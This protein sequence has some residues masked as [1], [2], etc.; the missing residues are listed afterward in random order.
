MEEQ[1][2]LKPP[3]TRPPHL[4]CGSK[5]WTGVALVSCAYFAWKAYGRVETGGVAWSHDM[6]AI[7]THLVWIVFMVGLLTETRCWK[8]RAFFVL[9]LINFALGFTMG[10]WHSATGEAVHTTRLISAAAWTLAS[11][12]SLVLMFQPGNPGAASE[13]KH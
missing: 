1:V 4:I 5:L 11:V 10:I 2:T 9:V 7:V 8:E 12:V 6:L 3:Q 13:G